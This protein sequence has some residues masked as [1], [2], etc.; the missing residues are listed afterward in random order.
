MSLGTDAEGELL[1]Q[2][3]MAK[4]GSQPILDS[5]NHFI[6]FRLPEIVSSFE[7]ET[8][9]G[10]VASFSN[11]SFVRPT[12]TDLSGNGKPRALFPYEARRKS[13]SYM[14]QVFAK[15][16]LYQRTEDK[17]IP[18]PDQIIDVFLGKIPVMILSEL[19]HLHGMSEEERYKHGEGKK[20]PG[21]YFIIGGSEKVLL[22][23]ERLRTLIPLMYE[24]DGKIQVRYTAQTL[25]E[26]PTVVIVSEDHDNVYVTFTKVGITSSFINIFYIFFIMGLDED[27]VERAFRIM[28]RFI[29]DE[30]P[31]REAK[32]RK[33]LRQYLQT[34]ANTF[35]KQSQNDPKEIFEKLATYFKGH[36]SILNAF[37]R[38]TLIK[39]TI[40]EELFKNISYIRA[41]ERQRSVTAS[42]IHLLAYMVVKYVEFKNGYRDLDDRD[43]WGNKRLVDPGSHMAS[44]FFQIWKSM[45][46][47]IQKNVTNKGLRLVMSIRNE[48]NQSC[49]TEQFIASFTKEL[50]GTAHGIK[51]VTIVDTLKRD[52]LLA[53]H[54]HIRRISTPTNRRAKIR[55]KRLIHNTQWGAVCPVM[56]P[57]G[58]ACYSC[59]TPIVLANGELKPIG[60]IRD[61]EEILTIDPTTL[62]QSVTKVYDHFTKYSK[63][64][65]RVT[66]I[67]GREAIVTKD[68]PFLTQKGWVEAKDLNPDLH[69]VAIWP[70]L[71]PLPHITGEEQ[72]ILTEEIFREKLAV[73]ELLDNKLDR[74]VSKLRMMGFLPLSNRHE[75]LPIIA[76]ICGFNL[77]G[78]SLS[79]S[80]CSFYF[81]TSYDRKLFLE[82]TSK[83]GFIMHVPATNGSSVLTVEA[84]GC[85]A[86]FLLALDLTHGRKV[87]SQMK[88]IP[89]WVLNG[90]PLVKR[91]FISGFQGGC[92]SSKIITR[93]C[94]Y[95]D[96]IDSLSVFMGQLAEL[97]R[98]FGI[99]APSIRMSIES[100]KRC[101]LSMSPPERD[102][103]FIHYMETIGYRYSTSKST[104]GYRL[105]E[106]LRYKKRCSNGVLSP[107]GWQALTLA[108]KNC[109]FVPIEVVES[110]SPCL[111]ADFTTASETHS[112]IGNNFITHN[113]GLVKDSAITAYVSLDR[114]ESFVRQALKGKYSL[115][116]AEGMLNSLFLNGAHLGFCDSQSLREY[117]VHLRRTQQLFFDT[118]IILDTMGDLWVYTNGERICRP[119]LVVDQDS[120]EL[121]I[122]V[123]RLR[124][125]PLLDLMR[126]GAIEYI[127]IAEQEQPYI[128]IAETVRHLRSR[129]ERLQDTYERLER[130]RQDPE[131]P[132]EELANAELALR[133]VRAEK[134]Y[135]HA[136]IDPTAILGIS[137]SIIPLL[138][139]NPAPRGTYQCLHPDTLVRTV[140]GEK[141]IKDIQIGDMVVTF[142]PYTFRTSFT[143]VINQII[144]T[145][146]KPIVRVRT[147]LGHEVICTNDHLFMTGHGW[148]QARD[149]IGCSVLHCSNLGKLDLI[150]VESVNLITNAGNLIADITTES[151]NHSFIANGLG[152]HNSGM[153]KQ[154]LGPNASRIELRFDTTMWT[155]RE[156]GVPIFSTDANERLGLDEF[157][158]G[159]QVMVAIT[160][161]G[162]ENQEDAIIFNRGSIERGLFMMTIYHSYKITVCQS[163]GFQEKLQIPK[164]PESQAS[165]YSKLDPTTAIV[166]LGE[167]VEGGD[168]LVGKVAINNA[169]GEVRNASLYVDAN[170]RGIIDEV[171][172]T[173]NAESCKLI[174][175]RIREYRSLQTGDKLASRYAQKGTIGAILPEEDM[176][177]VVSANPSI[178]GVRPD[179]IFN[180]HGLPSRMT[181]GKLIEMMTG[182]VALITGER[183]NA[184]AF[185]RFNDQKTVETENGVKIV[186]SW[187]S[188]Y[189]A[190]RDQLFALGFSRSGKERMVSGITGREMDAD[191]FIG[192][193]YYQLLRHLVQD[194]I[195]AR[196]T[197]VLQ[198]L[199][200]Q[201][202]SSISKGGGLRLGEME[203]DAMIEHGASSL[204]QER[205]VISSDAYQAIV[206]EGCGTLAISK[207]EG[208]FRCR[209]CPS[210]TFGR[211]TI[212]Y[213]FKLMVQLLSG[214]NIKLKLRTRES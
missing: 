76:R 142:D 191:I 82:D 128:Y 116:P 86:A 169:T 213:V 103:E 181:I 158:A 205:L 192:P 95:I 59:D 24:V 113:C 73:F 141:R 207:V 26:T 117:L 72:V 78:G 172:V 124:G 58:K 75:K 171:F 94:R 74:Y 9:D 140:D 36:S 186:A 198:F 51:D 35:L 66:T 80:S 40:R 129:I 132:P 7:I 33:E 87:V 130:L 27:T 22:N 64:T 126:E 125:R 204:L 10:N 206:C 90:S 175:I 96:Y 42:K 178:N 114:D 173:K 133:E 57:E 148:E 196:G 120:G 151:N 47:N 166:R 32:R 149:L 108:S 195:Q 31:I 3:I 21:G 49:M 99:P 177:F 109:I 63:D 101:L 13:L 43:A 168:C 48:I 121:V 111:V 11:V 89:D 4:G 185:R 136:E 46:T 139:F 37:N 8:P 188:N 199:T 100:P 208:E 93:Q 190:F 154:A 147:K 123:K 182:R 85:F 210:G 92:H 77:S 39:E 138:E 201:P 19:D 55:E 107:D 118:G 50:W 12:I 189:E 197:G 41:G 53:T 6:R 137:A 144:R 165:R 67:S 106:Y 155:I 14:A 79:P 170:R 143:R 187:G 193:V 105:S 115:R 17:R 15:L 1:R 203:R 174:R 52:T 68:H 44:R 25:T 176:P 209:A 161:Y 28:D 183:I 98:E 71:K 145:T 97:I 2:V 56:T 194:K 163:K 184:T 91:E 180:P 20:D 34:T 104:W 212:P 69:L 179:I 167:T 61:G 112:M 162:G 146:E 84:G 16:Q 157:P 156:P 5:Y 60:K 150:P 62:N 131:T 119:L 202:P 152:V 214:A 127:D 30:N 164:Y 45:I 110:S 135:T 102:D 122:D 88:P 83:L 211:V 159:R 70:G 134:R 200:R 29:V 81:R 65:L 160:T 153:G 23:I 54:A 18:I 38:N